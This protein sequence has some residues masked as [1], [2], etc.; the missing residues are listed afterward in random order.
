[1]TYAMYYGPVLVINE[2]GLDIYTTNVM[3]QLSELLTFIPAFFYIEKISRNSV[4]KLLF[5]IA[6]CAA[7]VLSFFEEPDEC[8]FCLESVVELIIIF[9]F[10]ACISFFFCFFQIY[11]CELFPSRARGMGFG[12]V[13]A[14][15]TLAST[16]SPIYLGVLR[17]NGLDEFNFFILFGIAAIGSLTLL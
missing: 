10:R 9:I 12:I 15:G 7:F 17:R 4:G 8:D 6:V 3:V 13:S 5:F 2:V 11:V 14:V 16:S 1:M